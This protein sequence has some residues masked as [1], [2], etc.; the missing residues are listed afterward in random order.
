MGTEAGQS[1]EFFNRGYAAHHVYKAGL[2][3][4]V[5]RHVLNGRR[6]AGAFLH[7]VRQPLHGDFFGVADVDDLS[8]SPLGVH[9]ADDTF[10]R[11]SDIAEAA[12]LLSIAV[13]ADGGVVQ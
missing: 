3:S 13:D 5:V 9:Q 4:S 11:V 6:A 1:M 8:D 10:D 2:V 12:G 7:A